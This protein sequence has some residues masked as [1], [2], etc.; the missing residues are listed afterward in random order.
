MYFMPPAEVWGGCEDPRAVKIDGRIYLTFNMFN[1]WNSMRVAFT[2]IAEKDLLIK[3]GIGTSL[4]IYL[5]QVTGRK[6][7]FCFQKKSTVSSRFFTI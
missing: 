5:T 2:S 7:G 6:T 3:N 1:G 4:P